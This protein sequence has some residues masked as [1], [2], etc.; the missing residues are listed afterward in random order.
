MALRPYSNLPHEISSLK[1]V[2]EMRNQE[3]H[4]LRRQKQDLEKQVSLPLSMCWLPSIC[5][6]DNPHKL[7]NQGH[8]VQQTT[9]YKVHNLDAVKIKASARKLL[10]EV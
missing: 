2:V 4:D 5:R 1:A 10:Q 6:N 7:V 8:K 9:K 3:I